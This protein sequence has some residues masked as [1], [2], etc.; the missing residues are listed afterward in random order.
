M[1]VQNACFA[2]A[3]IGTGMYIYQ[4]TP[5]KDAHKKMILFSAAGSVI[6]NYGTVLV[7]ANVKHYL[8]QSQMLRCLIAMGVVGG[9]FWTGKEYLN[10]VEPSQVD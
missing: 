5:H 10:H 8:P 2:L 6:F 7:L 3:H 9:L 4:H 1:L